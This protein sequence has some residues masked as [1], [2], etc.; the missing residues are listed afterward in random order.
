MKKF[1]AVL[2]I[3][4]MLGSFVSCGGDS[5]TGE[6]DE[7]TTVVDKDAEFKALY[8]KLFNDL[9]TLNDN[10]DTLTDTIYDVWRIVGVDKVM[11]TISYMLQI[12]SD[13]ST[14]WNNEKMMTVTTIEWMLAL[15]YGWLHD[16][17]LKGITGMN[18]AK[19]FHALCMD[20]QNAYN[21]VSKNKDTFSAE[22]KEMY[23]NYKSDYSYE[24]NLI[25]SLYLEVSVYADFAIE[26]AGSL[27]SY[28]AD[29]REMQ[30]EISKLIMAADI[31]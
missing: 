27:T 10:C 21:A 8:T 25:N 15:E 12:D 5:G 26:P 9:K 20:L 7:T 13:F 23:S 6:P 29:K 28:S 2:L 14:Y 4:V 31:Y 24:Y 16:G 1:F 18:D 30:A 11:D 3:L 22:I 17:P 19:E